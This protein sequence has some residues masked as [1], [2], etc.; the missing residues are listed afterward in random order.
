MSNEM[1][2]GLKKKGYITK[3]QLKYFPYEYRK[4]K[5]FGKLYFLPKCP[6]TTN[7]FELWYA[8]GKIL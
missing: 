6:R 1:F 3:K 7:Y 5:N 8:Y 4:D 2:S